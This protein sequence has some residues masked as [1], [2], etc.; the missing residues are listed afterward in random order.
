MILKRY[1]NFL[2]NLTV[3]SWVLSGV[4]PLKSFYYYYFLTK[5]MI[6]K[7]NKPPTRVRVPD[8]R[9]DDGLDTPLSLGGV[10]VFLSGLS[11]CQEF[12]IALSDQWVDDS[13][14]LTNA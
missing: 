11:F 7:E 14:F 6:Y 9:G 10:C 5:K 12:E 3:L 1:F 2:T 13:R 8:L 4:N